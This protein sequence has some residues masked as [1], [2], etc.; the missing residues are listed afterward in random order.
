MLMGVST[1]RCL[2][3]SH[4]KLPPPQPSHAS[5]RGPAKGLLA[6]LCRRHTGELRQGGRWSVIQPPPPMNDGLNNPEP[7][8]QNPL[9]P[10]ILPGSL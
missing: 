3:Y 4:R 7:I 8:P 6:T 9:P 5:G 10:A 2:D 1:T